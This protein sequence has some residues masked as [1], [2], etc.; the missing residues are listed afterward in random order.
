M[1]EALRS[2]AGWCS[3]PRATTTAGA[4]LAMCCSRSRWMGN[5]EFKGSKGSTVQ[6]FRVRLPDARDEA[7]GSSHVG[8]V[9]VAEFFEHHLLFWSQAQ[10]EDQCHRHTV[11]GSDN[12]IRQHEHLACG[13]DE[14][15]QVH[16]MSYE[17]VDSVGD[18]LVLVADFKRDGPIAP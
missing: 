11:R 3:R 15:R 18:K 4:C 9:L 6:R 10:G 5:N 16:R 14:E 7:F 13:V 8:P 2:P 12:P 1:G 17:A